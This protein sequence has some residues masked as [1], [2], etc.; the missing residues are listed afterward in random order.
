MAEVKGGKV[1]HDPRRAVLRQLATAHDR[2]AE[3]EQL[4]VAEGK[5]EEA[6]IAHGYALIVLRA[7]MAEMDDPPPRFIE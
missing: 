7:H 5:Y 3:A 2:F 4:R 1:N 6:T